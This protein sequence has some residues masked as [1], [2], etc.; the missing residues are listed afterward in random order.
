MRRRRESI[1]MLVER[2]FPLNLSPAVKSIRDLYEV[3]KAARWDPSELPWKRFDSSA[4]SPQERTSARLTWSRRAWVE[5]GGLPETPAL[6]VRFCLEQARE[7]DPK[8]F[9][10]V[11][12]TEIAWHTDSM[13][14]LTELLGGYIDDPGDP[15]V[16]G[17]Y[18]QDF[19]RAAFDGATPLDA[20]VAAHSIVLDGIDLELYR[21]HLRHT[22]D[23][24]VAEMLRRIVSD[25]ERHVQFGW[26]YLIERAPG[27]DDDLRAAARTELRAMVEEVEM[28]GY[29]VPSLG[30]P[31]AFDRYVEADSATAEAGLG[32]SS[33][34]DEQRVLVR[35]LAETRTRLAPLGIELGSFAHPVLG[36][37]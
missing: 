29:H 13:H 23:P 14:R 32:A 21:E 26:M 11:R 2:R 10:T 4:Y 12:G 17:V 20:Y 30:N 9:L 27:W 3:A 22:T 25:K 8:M 35:Y 31:A 24:L 15:L 5:Y 28:L 6:L 1:T 37:F 19:H 18:N 16:A 7:S 33:P 36:E 34:H